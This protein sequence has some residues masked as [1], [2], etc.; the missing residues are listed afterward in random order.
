MPPETK[1]KPAACKASR[2]RFGVGDNLRGVGAELG[3]QRLGQR[4][5]LGGDDVHERAALL[6]GEDGLV[7]GRGQVLRADDQAGARAAQSLVRGG[8]GDVRMRHGRRM[9]AAGDQ[10]GDVRHVEDVNRA[11]L[12]G[13]LAHAREVPQARIGAGAADDDLGLFLRGDG[14]HL[15]VV[16][17]FGVAADVIEG[18]AVELAAEA[19]PMAVGQVA[20]V[21]EIEAENGVAGLQHGRVGRGV[22]LRA[23]VRLHVDVLAAEDLARAIAGQVLDDVGVFAAAVVAASRVALGIFIGE[24]RAGRFE[25]GFRDEVFAGDHLQ[26]LV[27]A[28][29]FLV[30]GG[31]DFG[32][33][34]GE[35][36]RHAVSHI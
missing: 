33:G 20:A 2:E 27:L 36:E 9:H 35:G 23:G 3:A 22:G 31:G 5:G 1:R 21:R 30:N 10:A 25:H 4:D 26:P 12:V 13:D 29:G 6:A 11:H 17:G 18:G 34:L 28:E 15:V 16:D 14:F 24:D 8:G 19:E 7:D 32:I